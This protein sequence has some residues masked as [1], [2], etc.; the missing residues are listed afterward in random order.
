MSINNNILNTQVSMSTH[1][2]AKLINK[3]HKN[4]LRDV[5]TILSKVVDVLKFEH[6]YKDTYKREQRCYILPKREI[7]ILISGYSVELRTAIIDRLEVLEKQNYNDINTHAGAL[8]ELSKVALELSQALEKIEIDKPKIDC[9][10]RVMNTEGLLSIEDFAKIYKEK[11]KL[12]RNKVYK[13]LRDIKV[14]QNN[15]LP[16]QK[17]MKFFE[18]KE[19][20]IKVN[21][22]EILV[23]K[24]YVKVDMQE[25]L[26]KLIT[27]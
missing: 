3:E 15:N 16:Y 8:K 18:I 7:L 9:Y 2:I 27:L 26:L 6:I 13:Y 11:L 14:L 22:K 4:I 19:N 17:Y 24:L 5:E 25:R 1:E 23:K 10:D 12:G 21:N 20:T